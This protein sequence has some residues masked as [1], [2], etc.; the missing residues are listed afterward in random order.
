VVAH[1]SDGWE[2]GDAEQVADQQ[3]QGDDDHGIKK[4]T[5]VVSKGP[6]AGQSKSSVFL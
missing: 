3:Q 1:Q 4:V 6:A 2:E 5:A